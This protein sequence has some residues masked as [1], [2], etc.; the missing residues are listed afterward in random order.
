MRLA[1]HHLGATRSASPADAVRWMLA[2]QA[3]D[4]PGAKWSLALRTHGSTEVAVDAALDAGA[5]VRSWPLRGTLHLVAAEDLAWLLSLTGPRQISGAAARRRALGITPSDLE[6]ADA[7]VRA[8][9]AGRRSLPR[10]EVL[11]S[12]RAAGVATDGQ[13]GYHLLWHLSQSGT[14]VMGSTHG[15]GQTFALLDEWIRIAPALDRDEALGRLALRYLQSHGP[16]SDADLARWAGIPLGEARRGRAICGAALATIQ[17]GGTAQ[18]LD[19]EILDRTARGSR[20]ATTQ[21]LLLPGFDEYLLGYGD[22]SAVLAPEHAN[23]I[24]PGGN[25]VFRPTVVVDGEVVGTWSRMSRAREISVA[26]ELFDPAGTVPLDGLANA[27]RAFGS[28]LGQ[29]ARIASGGPAGHSAT[30]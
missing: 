14:L 25:G 23:R 12:I 13:R 16:A 10:D 28:F 29:E 4:L 27:V 26:P 5:V 2:V 19:P 15:R 30:P 22:R 9:L 24:V 7:A 3:Q 21:V 6:R 18:H 17:I 20:S 8:A 11:A 1:S